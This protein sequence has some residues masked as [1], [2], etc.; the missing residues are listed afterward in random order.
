MK[1]REAFQDYLSESVRLCTT[2]RSRELSLPCAWWGLVV[3]RTYLDNI[4]QTSGCG[5]APCNEAQIYYLHFDGI[6]VRHP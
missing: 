1:H 4:K 6:R 5:R 3:M 2:V